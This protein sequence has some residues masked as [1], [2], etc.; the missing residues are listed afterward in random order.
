M[1]QI[2]D[3]LRLQWSQGLSM[4][5]IA[6]SLGVAYGSVHEVLQRAHAA[7]LQWPLPAELDDGALEQLL[8]RGN[9]GRP[10]HRPDPVWAEVDTELRR[11]GVTLQLLWLEYKQAHPDDGY[12]YA[13]F[14]VHY[15]RWRQTQDVV[16]RQP[17]RAG[18][19]MFV[20]YAGQTIPLL[21]PH[22][23][24]IR[25]A[26]LFV[27]VLGA[28]NFTYAEAQDAQTLPHWI[29]GHTRAVAYFHGVAAVAV[30][31]N[32]KTAVHHACWYEPELNPTYADWAA[33]Y[34]TV[35]LP[36]RPRQPRDRAKGEA[37]VQVAE[38]WILAV[39]RHRTFTSV[40]EANAAIAELREA[41]NDRPFRKRDG[42]RRQLFEALDRPALRPLPATP[43]E[44]AQWK[45]AK[46][47]IDYH[48]VAD[49]NFYSVSYRLI[50]THVD[51]RL[52]AQ[53][54]EVLSQGR[55][56]ASHVRVYGRGIYVT[57]S[58]HR[59]AA[60]QRYLEWSPERLIQ[61]AQSVGPHTATLVE[62]ILRER[63]HPEH[64]LPVLSGHH[65]ARQILSA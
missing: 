44:Y 48:V 39:L 3:I 13:Q 43:Y 10:R 18:E 5:S 32:T 50:G 46:V 41:L 6:R 26:F 59:P 64:W 17:Y 60:H 24:E 53:T 55:R 22:T 11:K 9:Q 4:R 49:H 21:D 16:L 31:D 56:V 47:A 1:R 35:V 51:V 33:H 42:S 58:A 61:W 29:G 62:T 45:Q 57:D 25:Q 65:P 8:Y 7:G 37:G 19:K 23:G 14:C 36:A 20:D 34:G 28:S 30:P 38:R 40:A 2:K 12:Q 52:T 54:V 63:P 27:A 15:R